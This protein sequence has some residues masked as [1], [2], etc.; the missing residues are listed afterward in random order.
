VTDQLQLFDTPQQDKSPWSGAIVHAGNQYL[1]VRTSEVAGY[2]V[3][4]LQ[5][6]PANTIVHL[7]P[8][9]FVEGDD[10]EKLDGTGLFGY[11]FHWMQ[12]EE[13]EENAK[14]WHAFPLGIAGLFNHSFEQNLEYEMWEEGEEDTFGHVFEYDCIVFKTIRDI[15]TGEELFIDYVDG[16]KEDLWFYMDGEEEEEEDGLDGPGTTAC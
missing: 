3:F 5:D 13:E 16:K 4:A 15:T 9:L 10:V 1:A 12:Y 11:V 7:G 6:I 8:I 14:D 2:G